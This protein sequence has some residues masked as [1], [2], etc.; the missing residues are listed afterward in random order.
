M[1][2]ERQ[3]ILQELILSPSTEWHPSSQ[4]WL[5]L[6]VAEG[7]GFWLQ[8]GTD[9]RQLTVG[10]GL[11]ANGK[12]S[13]TLRAGQLGLLQ[14][15]FF[16]VQM[17][18]PFDL[19]T[20]AEWH[21]LQTILTNQSLPV[22]FFTH[23]EPVGQKFTRLVGLSHNDRLAERC[24]LL[25]LW[26][27]A[28]TGLL[29]VPAP[30]AA[31]HGKT[32]DRFRKVISQITETELCSTLPV[33]FAREIGCS[34]RHFNSLF[35]EEFGISLRDH[36]AKSKDLEAFCRPIEN[37]HQNTSR[38]PATMAVGI[39]PKSRRFNG[40]GNGQDSSLTV[41]VLSGG[42]SEREEMPRHADKPGT[43]K[44]QPKKNH[45]I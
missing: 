45:R 40:P 8:H 7:T 28:I 22:L 42:H 39:A 10:D 35:M 14:L 4:G 20:V 13:G 44:K 18:L 34:E 2:H 6:R 33:V 27:T 12:M 29:P 1:K 32:R 38:S 21:Q 37:P 5:I 41:G 11:I 19:L 25:Q 30:A 15:Q 23:S 9:A 36:Q 16:N 17:Q 31:N 3:L 43:G 26:A 24:A